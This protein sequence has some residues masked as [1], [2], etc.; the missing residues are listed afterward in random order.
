MDGIND[1]G[2]HELTPLDAMNNSGLGMM[3]MILG[4]KPMPLNFMNNSELW[5]T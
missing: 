4:S 2:S 1:S 3:L 5:L